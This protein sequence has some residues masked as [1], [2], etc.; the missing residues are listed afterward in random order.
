MDLPSDIWLLIFEYMQ[1]ID[2]FL[3]ARLLQRRM[4]RLALGYWHG[5]ESVVL[6][7][8]ATMV[9][10]RHCMVCH[11]RAELREAQVTMDSYPRRV[12]LHCDRILCCH[13]V[14]QSLKE[15]I[16]RVN[17]CRIIQNWRTFLPKK[18]LIRRSS[19]AMQEAEPLPFYLYLMNHKNWV[20]ADF[21]DN[22]IACSKLV[23]YEEHQIEEPKIIVF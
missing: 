7:P 3:S 15:C 12:F 19:G 17:E 2:D 13:A 8:R 20:R 22:G 23:A 14:I 4:A 10:M 9:D 6:H 1:R 16:C 11:R 18:I 5:L 21:C